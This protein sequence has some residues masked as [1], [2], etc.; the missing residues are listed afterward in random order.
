VGVKQKD[1]VTKLV[2]RFDLHDFVVM[3]F[4]YDGRV[5]AWSDLPDAVLH[6]SAKAQSKW[7]C[8][9]RPCGG[10]YR[11]I[12]AHPWPLHF[13]AGSQSGLLTPMSSASSS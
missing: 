12:G 4:H 2:S 5:D 1:A 3:L 10:R 6:V 13:I 7:W 8:V 9:Q 11:C